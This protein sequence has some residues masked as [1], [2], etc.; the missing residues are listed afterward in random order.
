MW[1]WTISPYLLTILLA[2]LIAH[3][4]KYVV[5]LIK[6]EK[7]NLRSYLFISGGMP[8]GHSATVIAMATIIGL[9][10]GIDTGIFGLAVLFAVI[11][12]YDA[13]K[14]RRSS[15]EQGAAI[16]GLIKE[17]KSLVELPRVARGHT[18][19]EV[20]CGALLGG[21]IGLVVFLATK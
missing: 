3:T 17:R 2:W 21:V 7:H 9:K 11:T 20:A 16:H 18:P 13:V 12:M 6:K 19:I 15:G 5:T 10:D 14:V 1:A 8:S 4:I